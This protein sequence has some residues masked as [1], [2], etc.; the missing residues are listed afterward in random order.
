MLANQNINHEA[1]ISFWINSQ[2]KLKLKK[3]EMKLLK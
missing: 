2:G 1:L 3:N